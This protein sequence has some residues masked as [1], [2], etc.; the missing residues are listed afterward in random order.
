MF[1]SC[2]L[3]NFK[4][5]PSIS[6]ILSLVPTNFLVCL[7]LEFLKILTVNILDYYLVLFEIY[8]AIFDSLLLDHFCDIYLLLLYIFHLLFYICYLGI[9]MSVVLMVYIC[10]L[11]FL[12]TLLQSGLFPHVFGNL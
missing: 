6:R 5:L 7:S 11:L 10:Y 9:I 3:S 1:Q 4:Y 12:P 8:V 2:S